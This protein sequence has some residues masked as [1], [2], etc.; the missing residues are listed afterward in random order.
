MFSE[1]DDEQ[2]TLSDPV[3]ALVQNRQGSR[4][5]THRT[6]TRQQGRTP[7]HHAAAQH[8]GAQHRGAGYRGRAG[9]AATQQRAET[10]GSSQHNTPG[11]T[12]HKAQR[13][14]TP[15]SDT[16]QQNT[17]SAGGQDKTRRKK[18]QDR[19]TTDGAPG[20]NTARGSTK[21]S[22]TKQRS[23]Q[24]RNA[25]RHN[26]QQHGA[27]Q[28]PGTHH[29]TPPKHDTRSHQ[30][31]AGDNRGQPG[32]TANTQTQQAPTKNTSQ[33]RKGKGA[34][35][36]EQR[37]RHTSTA[38][39]EQSTETETTQ[40]QPGAQDQ[41]RTQQ[42]GA[43]KQDKNSTTRPGTAP[44]Q[45]TRRKNPTRHKHPTHRRAQRKTHHRARRHT[46]RGTTKHSKGHH[47]RPGGG[48]GNRQTPEAARGRATPPV[49][50]HGARATQQAT[51]QKEGVQA[52]GTERRSASAHRPP[53][54]HKAHSNTHQHAPEPRRDSMVAPHNRQTTA[55]EKRKKTRE[56]GGR[57]T[58]RPKAPRAGKH[59]TPGTK[60]AQ[61]RKEGKKNKRGGGGHK[62]PRP[63]TP[64]AG[65]QETPETRGAQKERRQ[66]NPQAGQPQPGGGRADEESTK[67]GQ[68]NMVRRTKTR[69]GCRHARPSQEST[70]THTRDTGAWRPPTRKGRC[71]RPHET[72][73]VHRPSPLSK[74]GRYGKPDAS[75]TGSTHA[76]PPQRTQPKTEAGGTRQGQ[77]HCGAPKGYDAERAQRPC[78]G[79]GQPQAQRSRFSAGLHVPRA[80]TQ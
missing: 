16:P 4:A 70:H 33:R 48:G 13:R 15:R 8:R 28:Q 36:K 19:R 24:Q 35:H 78:L 29:S 54:K 67:N 62:T 52:G 64:R 10:T 72:A 44:R 59:G 75:V 18:A 21:R 66:E 51:T 60:G 1:E 5:G 3:R 50:L 31:A 27:A 23:A 40:N 7:Q 22:K 55:Q 73:L 6:T 80:A 25:R 49:R 9:S 45:T 69:P 76:K 41:Q 20:H 56:G 11:R 77:P 53:P 71:W 32:Q 30:D 14:T 63:K 68:R 46:A 17:H 47:N 57:K 61:K 65:K 39:H 2:T 26:A 34:P 38:P 12:R 58:P 79:R 42:R 43:A 74:D 37:R